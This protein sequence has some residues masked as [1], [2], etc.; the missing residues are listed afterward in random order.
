MA[1]NIGI[2]ISGRGSNMVSLIENSISGN[3]GG[4]RV[5]VVLSD[6]ENAP[7]L[8]KATDYGIKAKYIPT[9]SGGPKLT[10]RDEMDFIDALNESN[11]DVVCLAGFMRI[12]SNILINKFKE[13]LLNI[14]PSLLPSFKGLDVHKRVIEYGVRY[15]GCTV[16]FVTEEV[17]GGQ[18]ILQKCVPVLQ[19]DTPDTLAIRVLKEEHK[20]YPQAVKLLCENRLRIENRKVIID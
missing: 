2:L 3:L 10:E 19:N 18:I 15:T 7:G 13:R 4:G 6:V 12:L 17:D 16:H 5:V 11:V 8:E 9:R 20:I 14:H 1:T